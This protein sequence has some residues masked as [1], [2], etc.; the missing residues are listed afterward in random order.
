[1]MR[2]PLVSTRWALAVALQVST[3]TAVHVHAQAVRA[4]ETP[5]I[6]AS[7][8]ATDLWFH[9]LAVLGVNGPG[10]LPFYDAGYART[11]SREK[12]GRGIAPSVL[13]RDGERLRHAIMADS[14]FELLHF[15]P[16]YL[17]RMSPEG[18]PRFLRQAAAPNPGPLAPQEVV[19]ALRSALS[20]S[21]ERAVLT[22]LADAIEDEWQTY[23]EGYVSSQATARLARRS[24]VQARWDERFAPQLAPVF[25][26]LGVSR[27]ILL[28]SPSLGPEGRVVSLG[29]AGMIVAVAD[30]GGIASSDAPLL[31]LVRE[32]CFPLLQRI[33]AIDPIARAHAARGADES[34]RA[35]VRCGAQL[36][37]TLMPSSST[38]YRALFLDARPGESETGYRQRFDRRFQ[39]DAA[40]LRAVSREIARVASKA[41]GSSP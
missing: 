2:Q 10:T 30:G 3:M 22:D 9:S 21:V 17:D 26:V 15:L 39:T 37:D 7:D 25:R 38:E 4:T 34:S 12:A 23:F 33:A 13:D 16:L 8:A 40:T 41:E 36:V 1:M 28:T 14:A 35:A 18:L 31:A 27:G 6:V 20:A 24:V 19:T 5:W 11:V 32:L 29:T